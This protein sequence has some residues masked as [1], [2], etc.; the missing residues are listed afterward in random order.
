MKKKIFIIPLILLISTSVF[1]QKWKFYRKSLILTAGTF[2]YL[3][4]LGGG[5]GSAKHFMGVQDIDLKGT[6]YNVGF[7]MDYILFHYR[8]SARPTIRLGL[9]SGSDIHTQNVIRR[10]RNLHFK[11]RIIETSV[12][13]KYH[14]KRPA[15]EARFVCFP[16]SKYWKSS[17]YV[18]AGGGLFYYNPKAKFNDKWHTLKELKTEGQGLEEISQEGY[19]IS[20]PES[21]SNFAGNL[22]IGIGYNKRSQYDEGTTWGIEVSFRYTTTDYLDDVSTN[23]YPDQELINGNG[24][25]SAR[26]ADMRINKNI[27]GSKRGNSEFNDSY[28]LINYVLQI[29]MKPKDY[30]LEK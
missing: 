26:F 10:N 3:G 17:F 19:K 28:F 16:G 15:S 24:L 11:S 27:G 25:A 13:F 20:P 22:N 14:I 18:L 6:R 7:G 30:S 23:Y 21:Y 12:D 2:N 4:D 29:R 9:L 5:S 1:S 8:F